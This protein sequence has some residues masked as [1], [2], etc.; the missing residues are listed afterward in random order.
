MP[1]QAGQIEGPERDNDSTIETT[2]VFEA[3]GTVVMRAGAGPKSWRPSQ[4][5]RC[6]LSHDGPMTK[7]VVNTQADPI[8]SHWAEATELPRY[9]KAK[10]GGIIP[11]MVAS[12]KV[13]NEMVVKP[14]P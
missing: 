5:V 2:D 10:V 4:E 3:S 6:R 14:A 11:A 9:V 1:P 7:T 12:E 8:S 13:R